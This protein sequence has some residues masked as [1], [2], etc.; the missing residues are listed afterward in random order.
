VAYQSHLPHLVDED[1]L[2][3]ANVTLESTPRHRSGRWAPLGGA[4]VSVLTA[5]VAIVVRRDRLRHLGALP[6]P[7]PRYLR[8]AAGPGRDE[9]AVGG[10]RG[11]RFVFGDP[12]L[13]AITLTRRDLQ[14]VRHRRRV[15]AAGA[16][17]RRARALAVRL[18]PGL[19]RR[20]LGGLLGS[21]VT[22]RVAARFGAG[23]AMCGSVIVSGLLW[24][25]AV[26]MFQADWRY[27]IGVALQGLGWVVF[28]T[29]KINAV[30]LRQ[31]WCP[32]PLLGRMTASVR[33]VVWGA[34]PVGALAGS[35]LGPEPRRAPGDVGRRAGRTARRAPGA[36]LAA[37]DDAGR[38]ST[39]RTAA[40]R[41]HGA[42]LTPYRKAPLYALSAGWP[43][44]WAVQDRGVLGDVAAP[45]EVDQAGHRLALVDRVEDHAFE[46]S[47]EPDG[48]DGGVDG[49]P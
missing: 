41:R 9:A 31:R 47:G 10:R 32:T 1:R 42:A 17:G 4:L 23:R 39:R 5:P 30:T 43:P 33:F 27:A 44:R 46:P 22:A 21:L 35:A 37:A 38:R 15:D 25:L 36:A 16:A 28:M 13:R 48:V 11:L 24:M 12:V 29:F 8:P 7:D 34:M 40:H 19:H 49:M 45:D 26:P 18:W 20:G 3:A 2:L 14:P 6:G